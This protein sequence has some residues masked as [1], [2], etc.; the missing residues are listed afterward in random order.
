MGGDNAPAAIVEGAVQACREH[1]VEIVLVGKQDPIDTIIK[2]LDASYL[3]ITVK[4]T[5]QVIE[6]ADNP[7]D[8]VRKKKDSSIKVGLDLVKEG[9]ADAFVS[10]GNS[11][12][13]AAG[14]LFVLKRM[15]GI[16]RPSIASPMP[17]LQGSVLVA[18]AGANNIV[19]PH[20]LVQFAIMTSVYS[21][22]YLKCS[23]PRVGL[24]SNGEEE[25]KGTDVIKQAHALLKESSL[26]YIGYVEGNDV[27]KGKV[28]VVACDGFTGNVL[29]KAAEG[30][31]ECFGSALKEAYTSS[32]RSKL[33]YL[34]SKKAILG[35]KERFDYSSYGGAPLLGVQG[36]VI[37]SHGKSTSEAMKN[38]V[39]AAKDFAETKV[40]EHIQ[41][42][43]EVHHDIETIGKKPSIIDRVLKDMH[44]K[45]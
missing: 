21:K 37:I 34:F 25:S 8:V 33:G 2:H 19:K 22:Y 6:M 35:F 15:E 4:N 43:K 11:G 45:D 42:D 30:V 1:K 27:F 10:A 5:S 7:L 28:D 40:V 29:L 23:N 41:S 32:L 17:S 18:D 14:A 38:A 9:K 20:N 12:A 24:L 26:N 16:D 3:P 13:V 36:P 39:R 31:A 44:L